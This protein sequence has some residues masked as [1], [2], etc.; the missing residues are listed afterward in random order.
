MTRILIINGNPA[1]QRESFSEALC[2]TYREAATGAGHEVRTLK[3]ADLDFDPI[4]HEGY[5]GHQPPE[6]HVKAAQDFVAWSEHLVFVYPM[7]QFGVPALLKGFCERVFAPGFAYSISAKNP[8]EA[9]LLKGGSV[10]LIQTMGMPAAL[11]T[12]V[13][14]GHGAK[15]FRSL[16]SF[17]GF[18]PVRITLLG[19]VEGPEPIRKR[20]LSCV[21][22][23][24]AAAR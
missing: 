12:T 9:A 13:F 24:G 1:R 19:M 18:R 8:L 17:C 7:W 4:L 15:A 20:H 5:H 6:P 22:K 11:Y 16:F 2:N 10:R 3:I 14:G 23:L 21:R